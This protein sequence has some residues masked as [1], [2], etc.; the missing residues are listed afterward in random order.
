M[1][2]IA[3]T[4]ASLVFLLLGSCAFACEQGE[5]RT[6]EIVRELRS[7]ITVG[8]SRAEVEQ[9]LATLP[10]TY[11]YVTREDLE[12]ISATTFE[13]KPL[14][15]RF[16]VLTPHEPQPTYMKQAAIHI[17]LGNDERVVNIQIQPFGF[18]LEP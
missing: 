9:R 6:E 16:D 7:E 10:V 14:S 5:M 4:I 15:G 2:E 12:M 18:V 13:G 17:E 8:M 1:R 11:T 3:A